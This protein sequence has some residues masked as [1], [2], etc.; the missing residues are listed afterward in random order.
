MNA[1]VACSFLRHATKVRHVGDLIGVW[2]DQCGFVALD[3]APP[4]I[5]SG[6]VRVGVPASFIDAWPDAAPGELQEAWGK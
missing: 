6:P 5:E 3:P 1:V 2:C 4:A